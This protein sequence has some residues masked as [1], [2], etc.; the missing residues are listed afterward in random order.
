MGDMLRTL[1]NQTRSPPWGGGRTSGDT[2]ITTYTRGSSG[3]A[4]LGVRLYSESH[5]VT[6]SRVRVQG[7][8]DSMATQEKL[9]GMP[10]FLS[11]G[12]TPVGE[13]PDSGFKRP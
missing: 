8:G 9:W 2:L 5:G 11:Q 13:D 7:L 12:S 3:S 10:S 6:Q 4:S 1:R